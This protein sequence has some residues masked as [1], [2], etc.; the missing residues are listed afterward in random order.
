MNEHTV[1][2][3]LAAMAGHWPSPPMTT[4][5]SLAWVAYL[6]DPA[7]AVTEDEAMA[8]IRAERDR[9]FRPRP[10]QLEG[11]V[12]AHRRR[13]VFESTVPAL[14]AAGSDSAP[15]ERASQWI[16]AMRRTLQDRTPWEEAQKLEGVA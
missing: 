1:R 8:I 4:E 7:L 14:R 12:H 5:E 11:L 3:I 2:P 15:P 9:E 13:R 10:G 6:C 16:A